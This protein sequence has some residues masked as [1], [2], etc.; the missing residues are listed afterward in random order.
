MTAVDDILG[1]VPLAEIARE[2]GVSEAEAEVLA[3]QSIPT[4][5][6]GM[7]A[8]ASDPGGA[9]SL[10]GAL[11]DHAGEEISDP[12]LAQIDTHDG[13]KIVGNIFGANSESVIQSL[14]ARSDGGSTLIGKLLPILAPIVLKYLAGKVLGGGSSGAGST[15]TAGGGTAG[16]G[17]L[18]QILGE[19]LGG[20]ASAPTTPTRERND[21]PVRSD[22]PTFDGP[23]TSEGNSGL[24]VPETGQDRASTDPQDSSPS[25]SD[26][27]HQGSVLDSL[28]DLFGM[29][30][31]G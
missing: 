29:G 19:M 14:G 8:N 1:R 28:K 17:M 7:Q 22:G 9:S 10:E 21:A 27:A 16:G 30:R 26:A 31:R 11:A 13:S 15:G 6:G 18:G 24:T 12:S 2:L 20:R 25:D 4:L 23:T 5:L 3:R